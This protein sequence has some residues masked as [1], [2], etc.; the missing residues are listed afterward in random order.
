MKEMACA[1]QAGGLR[2]EVEGGAELR[3]SAYRQYDVEHGMLPPGNLHR[4]L[5]HAKGEEYSQGV[6]DK[7]G[8]DEDLGDRLQGRTA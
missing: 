6:L 7:G 5:L 4:L 8:H 3:G 1:S 2:Q